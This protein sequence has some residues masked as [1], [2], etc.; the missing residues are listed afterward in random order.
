M[1]KSPSCVV[2]HP[3]PA[4]ASRAIRVRPPVRL[5]P[6]L[7]QPGSVSETAA[8]AAGLW[9]VPAGQTAVLLAAVYGPGRLVRRRAAVAAVAEPAGCMRAARRMA[10]ASYM[11]CSGP[12]AA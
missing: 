4:E 7:E 5:A 6:G 8:V 9:L 11:G 1:P 12:W 10:T 2:Y 3:S